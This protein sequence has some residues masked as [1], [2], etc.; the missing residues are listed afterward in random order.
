MELGQVRRFERG[1][2]Q[3]HGGKGNRRPSVLQS[4]LG[5]PIDR[6]RA[7][8]DRD[9]LE[10]EDGGNV[11]INQIDQRHRNKDRLDVIGEARRLMRGVAVRVLARIFE[12]VPVKRVPERLIHLP[13]VGGRGAKCI[14]PL[15]GERGKVGAVGDHQRHYNQETELFPQKIIHA[16]MPVNSK[17]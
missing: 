8:G 4:P 5:N 1:Q 13:H 6:D 15:D 10:D 11:V 9:G 7:E 16:I 12:E 2:E 14:L 17:R 3:I